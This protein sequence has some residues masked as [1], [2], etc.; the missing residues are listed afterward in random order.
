MTTI[1]LPWFS[2]SLATRLAAHSAAPEEIPHKIPSSRA[3]R[4]A[5][6]NASSSEMRSTLSTMSRFKFSG[7]KPAPMPWILCLPG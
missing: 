7:M 5:Q 2:G 4:L 1:V 3:A 6:A